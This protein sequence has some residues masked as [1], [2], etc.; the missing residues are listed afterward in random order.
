MATGEAALVTGAGSGIGL[1]V[2]P[3][4]VA[5]GVKV[6]LID[7]NEDAFKRAE[8]ALLSA[9]GEVA[10]LPFD[11][12]DIDQWDLVADRAEEVLGPISILCNIAGANGDGTTE[13][14]P[15]KV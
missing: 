1:G 7:V 10:A 12:S 15:L 13:A 3:A 11:V 6:A 14:T 2:A 4:L 9:G 8:Q 5:A